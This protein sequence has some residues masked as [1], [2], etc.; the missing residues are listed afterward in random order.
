MYWRKRKTRRG[1]RKLSAKNSANYV[2]LDLSLAAPGFAVVSVKDRRPSLIAVTHYK[3]LPADSQPLRYELIESFALVWLRDIMRKH[4]EISAV[5]RETWP[6]SRNPDLN[7]KVHGAWS[8]VDRALSRVGLAVTA[9]ITPTSVKKAVTGN[10]NA[11]KPEVADGVRRI[12]RLGEDY[13][14]ATDDESDACAVVLA[15]LIREKLIDGG[16]A[17]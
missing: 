16:A 17:A 3:T 8:A 6:P 1:W 10:G 9:N 7:D 11:K 15:W 4:G 12:L 14:F 5:I 2:G 13:A